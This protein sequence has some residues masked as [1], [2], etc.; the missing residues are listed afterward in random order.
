MSSL[1]AGWLDRLRPELAGYADV[2]LDNI[3]REFPAHIPR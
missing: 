2:A 1:T 3:G